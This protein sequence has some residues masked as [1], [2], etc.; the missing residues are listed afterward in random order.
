MENLLLALLPQRR[1]PVAF[2][3]GATSLIIGA[4]C[5]L[6][7]ALEGSL[8]NYPLLLF[9]PAVF[10]AA[11]L[12][13]KGSGFFATIASALLAAY[14]FMPPANGFPRSQLVPLVLFVLIG[15]TIAWVTE[16]LRGAIRDLRAAEQNKAVL[17]HELAHR[18]KND[19][20]IVQSLLTLQARN[21]SPP[22]AAALMAAASRVHVIAR[23]QGRLEFS[24]DGDGVSLRPY[25]EGLCHD[26]ADLLRDVRPIAVRLH[27]ADVEIDSSKAV[28]VGLIVNELVANAFKYAF[29][30]PRSGAVDVTVARRD[31]DLLRI[32]VRDDGIGCPP[33]MPGGL[34]SRLVRLLA[35][36]HGGTVER[37]PVEPGCC[38]VASVS[39]AGPSE[40][41][42]ERSRRFRVPG[43]RRQQQQGTA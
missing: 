43:G 4:A 33:D 39:I 14:L 17:L 34:G 22:V 40:T 25:L 10:L 36:Q 20:T 19:L 30:G 37:A 41:L 9:I 6:R 27:C 7:F 29:P 21:E 26:L 5:L 31:E 3:Y 12:F 8:A 28:A 38:V 13:D 35:Q 18:T 32:E 2:R 23:A 11:L 24:D 15:F 16:A 42:A 1:F